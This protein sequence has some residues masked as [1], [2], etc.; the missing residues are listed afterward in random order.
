MTIGK[1]ISVANELLKN[2]K[3]VMNYGT[4][5]N[6]NA[7]LKNSKMFPDK[8]EEIFHLIGLCCRFSQGR[9]LG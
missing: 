8:E 6:S 3:W 4:S 7:W 2:S 9:T 1:T 5:C